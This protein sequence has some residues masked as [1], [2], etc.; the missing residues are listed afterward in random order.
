[1]LAFSSSNTSLNLTLSVLV[2]LLLVFSSSNTNLSNVLSVFSLLRIS[3]RVDVAIGATGVTETGA[4]TTGSGTLQVFLGTVLLTLTGTLLCLTWQ[5][6][7]G[8]SEHFV[9]G[10]FAQLVQNEPISQSTSTTN[11]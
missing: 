6:C 9:M 10:I 8:T 7:L 11:R 2:A 4:G 1:M 5:I 3:S